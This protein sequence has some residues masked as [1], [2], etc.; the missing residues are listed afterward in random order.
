M[1]KTVTTNKITQPLQR[2][3]Q[4]I[5]SLQLQLSSG[6]A[7]EDGLR[8]LTSQEKLPNG[9]VVQESLANL[10]EFLFIKLNMYQHDGSSFPSKIFHKM[11]LNE[12]L[13]IPSGKIAIP[14]Y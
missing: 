9:W 2:E 8:N 12:E 4:R 14:K 3:T 11:P 13:E 10:P 5:S 7:I 1:R 6:M